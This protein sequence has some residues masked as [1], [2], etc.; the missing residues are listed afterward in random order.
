MPSYVN[1]LAVVF[2]SVCRHTQS[3]TR[4]TN[5]TWFTSSSMAG[6]QVINT[7]YYTPHTHNKQD[8]QNNSV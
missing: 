5:N 1:F 7:N 4:T 6:V 8:Y 3:H 2:Q